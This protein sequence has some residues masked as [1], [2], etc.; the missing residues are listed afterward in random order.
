MRGEILDLSIEYYYNIS[1]S[2]SR[3]IEINLI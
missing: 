1:D 2:L 3:I